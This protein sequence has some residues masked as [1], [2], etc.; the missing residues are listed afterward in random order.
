MT[1]EMEKSKSMLGM[2]ASMGLA[3]GISYG[4]LL[5]SFTVGVPMGLATSFLAAIVVDR[6]GSHLSKLLK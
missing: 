5:N 3:L 2:W 1:S 6:V 4:F